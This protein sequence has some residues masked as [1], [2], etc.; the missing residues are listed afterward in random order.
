MFRVILAALG[1][2]YALVAPAS[3][4]VS[5][6][7]EGCLVEGFGRGPCRPDGV[8]LPNAALGDWCFS[9]AKHAHTRAKCADDNFLIVKRNS[10]VTLDVKCRFDKIERKADN[11][12]LVQSTCKDGEVESE[13]TGA[14]YPRNQ[15]FKIVG[16]TLTIRP[17]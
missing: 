17:K 6:R 10:F 15:E 7:A 13:D 11:V 8:S 9:D 2:V 1:L 12:Y 16:Q 4:Q 5:P 14:P 3:A